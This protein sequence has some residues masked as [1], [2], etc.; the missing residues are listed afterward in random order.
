MSVMTSTETATPAARGR[1]TLLLVV[2]GLFLVWSH[3][4][5]AFEVLLRPAG[6]HAAPMDWLDLVVA[7]VALVFPIAAF[8]SFGPRRRE[9]IEVL[10][11]RPL[12]VLVA[13]LVAVPLYNAALYVGIEHGVSGP[14]ASLLTTMT[15]LYLV[16]IGALA[17]GE[18][19]SVR[20]LLGLA[21]GFGGVGL[22]ASAQAGGPAGGAAWPVVVAAVAPLG[23]SVYTALT[24]R[25]LGECSTATWTFLVLTIGSVPL[26]VLLPF[27]G[28]PALL[29]LDATGWA[30][31][32]Y[33]SLLS[34]V[35]GNAV[36]SWLLRRL[37]ASTTGFTI[38]L[39]PPLTT[40]SKRALAWAWPATF[41]FSI[42]PTQ[43]VGGAVALA[44]VALVVISG[45]REAVARPPGRD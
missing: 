2:L 40:A 21:L 26:V 9:S 8:V 32:L 13:A 14:I 12:R 20:K 39:N 29:R 7:R 15:P 3:T 24:K 16:A 41:S 31:L 34:T 23:W 36:W 4:F 5:L 17:L 28:G 38:F 25:A 1:G 11:R 18:R 37:P 19:L 30:L 27:A 45:S 43:W 35:G 44:G 10:C 42:A 22:I 6:G 33:L